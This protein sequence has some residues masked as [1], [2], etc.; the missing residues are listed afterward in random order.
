MLVGPLTP[1]SSVLAS[2]RHCSSEAESCAQ[3]IPTAQW[4]KWRITI[5][6]PWSYYPHRQALATPYQTNAHPILLCLVCVHCADSGC[7]SVL[8]RWANNHPK[9]LLGRRVGHSCKT[10]RRRFNPLL[11]L[12]L[13]R[14]LTTNPAILF[15]SVNPRPSRSLQASLRR[16]VLSNIASDHRGLVYYLL[17]PSERGGGG[18]EDCC[19]NKHI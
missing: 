9:G 15:N 5:E 3:S 13:F 17:P 10:T 14:S 11:S 18:N 2:H 8:L 12:L 16:R 4:L 7:E 19:L 6:T 1:V